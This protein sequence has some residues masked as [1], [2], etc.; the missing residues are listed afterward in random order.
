[1]SSY[2]YDPFFPSYKRRYAESPRIHHVSVR[3][4]GAFGSARSAYSSLSAP[5]SSVSVRRSY[6]T[7][8][9]SG[10]LLHSV[11]SLDLSQVAAIS[12][13]LKSIRSQERA[14][15][16]DLNDRF[17]CF[18]ERVHELEQQNKVL[19][20]E[21]LVLRQKHAEPSRFRALYEQEIRE[22]RLAAE[23]ATSEKQ[24]LQG[25]R[26]SLEETLR[27]LQ[28]RYEEEVLSR[29]DAEA[30]LLEVRKGADEAAL[31]RAELEK[32]VD[33]LLDELAFL[34][35]VHE[36]EL[37]ELQAQIQ[38]AH[39]SVEMDVSAKPD[40]SA[41]LRDIRAQYEKLAARNMQN[42]EEWF[43]S[44][45]TVLSE[46]A[47]KNTDAVRAA[48]DEVSESRRLLS[49]GRWGPAAKERCGYRG[50][51]RSR[52]LGFSGSSQ[53]RGAKD[54]INKLENELRTTKS[55]MARYLKEYQDLLNVKM[56]LDIEIA[57]YRKLL[58]GEETRLSFTS[59]GSITSGYTQSAPSFGRSAYSGLQSSSYL[60]TTRSFPTYYS[61]HVQ[62]EQIEIEETIE[63]AKAGEAKAAPA[64]EG[65]EEEEK[66]EGEE[67]AG[68]EEAEEEEE[69][70]AKE[71][72]EEAKEGEEEEG[73]G[74]ETAAEEGEESQETAEET[75][76]DEK[77][78][79]EEKEAAGK[80]E[81]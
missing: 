68:G 3:S 45:F 61:S 75:G 41:A 25:E 23:E 18:I 42:A 21:L 51:R 77:E 34:K 15:L 26:E 66:E 37:A 29:E 63:A 40:L 59:V 76:E 14:Q 60:M 54:T 13:D 28:A 65:E 39:L 19:E 73:E 38:Y 53:V 46:S 35:K 48:K 78:E 20:A 31:A 62:E 50:S 49:E 36:E 55:E 43:R 17:A 10:S 69:E 9:A 22:L 1:M 8:S 32:R 56:A 58:E 24:A 81:T 16:Q 44:R 74:E 30:R 80:E 11:D 52:G 4:G 2:G 67:E 33:S 79:K 57:A 7:S 70:G 71:E 12:N 5:V 72:S 27:G 6:A 47:A 64:E